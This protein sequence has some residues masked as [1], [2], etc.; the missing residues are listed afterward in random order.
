MRIRYICIAV[1][2]FL[3]GSC[4]EDEYVVDQDLELIALMSES[5]P[6][7]LDHYR[8]PY[9]N[10]LR[11]I[12]YDPKNPLT[13]DKVRLGQL[14][15]HETGFATVGMFEE[16][17]QT[18]SCASCH[19]VQ[20]GFQ[21]NMPQGIGDGGKGFGMFGEGRQPEPSLDLTNIDVQPLRTPSAMNIA[22]QTNMLWNG[23]FGA[24]H[25]NEGTEQVW[26]EDGPIS[27]NRLGYQGPEV[28]AV[29]GL[30]VHRH[31]YT[32]EAV[33]EM[34]YKEMF[35]KVFPEIDAS[36]RY[37]NQ[38]AGL[39]IAAYERTLL[40]H[41]SPFQRWLRGE[42]DAMSKGQIDGAI[43][44]FGKGE[45]NTCHSG[46][47]L[48]SMEFY[49]LGMKD[50]DNSQAMNVDPDA[51]AHLGRAS[52]TKRAEDEYKFKVPQLYNLKDSPFYGHG[53]SFTSVREV[54]EYKNEA[55]AENSN[56][57][58]YQVAEEFHPLS[59]TD[60][61]ID[62]LV[63]FIENALYDPH[64]DRYVPAFLESGMCF[65]NNDDVSRRDLG[66]D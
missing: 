63:D 17:K 39:A 1:T 15:F 27:V 47:G 41:E 53:S 18:Y 58:A 9:S 60:S 65:P 34:G 64:L 19:H 4:A 29:A 66:C 24:T 35:D 10:Q 45:C 40:A 11:D 61:E 54:I 37:S 62:Q 46:P 8:M 2:L 42:K 26:P 6:D 56:V 51:D 48:A 49:A 14:L 33:A 20:G 7:G 23:Q 21:A 30:E 50:L 25:M 55:I 38:F 3:L 36:V 43:I 57:P 12:P 28:Q 31:E 44:F 16:M 32:T 13:D 22:Y 59:L 52:F 5:H